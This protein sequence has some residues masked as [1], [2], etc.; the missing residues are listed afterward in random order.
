MTTKVIGD[1]LT[2]TAKEK[3]AIDN[4]AMAKPTDMRATV[5]ELADLKDDF[6]PTAPT[7]ADEDDD[8]LPF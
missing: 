8:E 6:A 7:V 5:D 4:A 2:L 1:N 3:T